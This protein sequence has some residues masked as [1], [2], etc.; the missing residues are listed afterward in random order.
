MLEN[1]NV[2]AVA[3][4]HSEDELFKELIEEGEFERSGFSDLLIGNVED[5]VEFLEDA[6]DKRYSHLDRVVPIDDSFVLPTDNFTDLLKGYIAREIDDFEP[7]DTYGFFVERQGPKETVS[8]CREIEKEVSGYFYALM[9]KI[10]GRKPKENRKNPDKLIVIEI[11]GNRC[12]IGVITCEMREKY[13][14][15]R[16][17]CL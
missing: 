15:I 2:L 10:H 3:E 6:E 16:V 1:W 14:M 8:S 7:M 5:I 13:S 11:V 4:R 17:K 9:E 12:G